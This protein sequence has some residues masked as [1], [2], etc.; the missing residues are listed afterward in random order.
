MG[1]V[2]PELK[3]AFSGFVV[4]LVK[5]LI[6]DTRWDWD[7]EKCDWKRYQ[8]GFR[9]PSILKTTLAVFLN[10][11]RTDD[12]GVTVNFRYA[13]FRA[14]QYFRAHVDPA[15]PLKSVQPPFQ[16]YEIEEPD[17]RLWEA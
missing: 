1:P 9:D 10:T 8:A 13:R 17:W 16:A 4:L 5:G 12:S 7:L 6:D 15:Y 3:G 2:P 14:F 11:L